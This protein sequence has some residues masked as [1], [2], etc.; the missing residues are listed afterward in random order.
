MSEQKAVIDEKILAER[1]LYF[2][3]ISPFF[4]KVR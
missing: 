1:K 4:K 3:M 2:L